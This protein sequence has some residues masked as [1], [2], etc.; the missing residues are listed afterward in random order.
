[1]FRHLLRRQDPAREDHE[2]QHRAQQQLDKRRTSGRASFAHAVHP[3]EGHSGDVVADI[4]P[5]GITAVAEKT[6]LA[7]FDQPT[8]PAW[9]ARSHRSTGHGTRF[10]AL[11]PA[12][13]CAREGAGAAAPLFRTDDAHRWPPYLFCISPTYVAIHGFCASLLDSCLT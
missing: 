3:P 13:R 2:R 12:E 11:R 10:R 4:I 7:W 6:E 5:G 9:L 1:R 8:Q